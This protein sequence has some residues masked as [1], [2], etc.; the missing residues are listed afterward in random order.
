MLKAETT[1]DWTDLAGF[2]TEWRI[3]E[4][5]SINPLLCIYSRDSIWTK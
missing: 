3:I 2:V 5:F 1:S 4:M